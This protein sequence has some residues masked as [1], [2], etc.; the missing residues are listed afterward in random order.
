MS[1]PPGADRV[2]TDPAHIHGVGG[3]SDPGWENDIQVR[4]DIAVATFDGVSGEDSAGSTCLKQS[5]GADGQGVDIYRL[6][7]PVLVA[8]LAVIAYAVIDTLMA[9]RY[10]TADL[11]EARPHS[12]HTR[13]RKSVPGGEASSRG[14]SSCTP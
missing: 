10:A 6:A 9:G 1:F 12:T 8:Q 13:A 3:Y 11:A 7:W 5:P 4:G 2:D 14:V